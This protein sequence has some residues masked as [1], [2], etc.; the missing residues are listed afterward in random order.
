MTQAVGVQVAASA[1]G[2]TLLPS[3]IGLA[4]GAFGAGVVAPS[5][6]VLGLAMAWLYRLL[7]R[8][9]PPG[10]AGEVR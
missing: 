8:V 4:V 3:G 2:G 1:V 6:F 9:T 5:L 10:H 7:R